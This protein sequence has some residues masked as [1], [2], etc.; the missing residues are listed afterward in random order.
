V[1]KSIDK[2][3]AAPRADP[4]SAAA[5]LRLAVAYD[6]VRYKGCA[7]AMLRRLHALGANTKLVPDQA[8]RIDDLVDNP[9]WFKDYRKE[10]LAAANP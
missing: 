9:Q 3:V 5:T 4:Y 6:Q 1:V 8:Q 10:A 7:L 2:Y